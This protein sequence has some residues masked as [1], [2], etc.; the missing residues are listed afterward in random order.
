MAVLSL[1]H[2]LHPDVLANELVIHFV[3]NQGVLWNLVDA[4]SS[5]PG[6]AGM[7]HTTA[8]RQAQLRCRV[9]Y[10]YVASKANVS[11]MPSRDDP[12]Y[13]QILRRLR[14]DAPI[15]WFQSRIPPFGW[16]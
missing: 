3:D 10:D 4:S 9:W 5:D 16:D 14:P 7:T 6:C 13:L 8:L 11:D 1:Y 2:S 15:M 12:A